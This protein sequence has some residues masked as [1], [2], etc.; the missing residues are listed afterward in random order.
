MGTVVEVLDTGGVM[1]LWDSFK[2][3]VQYRIGKDNEG[4]LLLDN[5]QTATHVYTNNEFII[6]Q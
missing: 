6:L 2:E 5:A 3:G 4:L 1:V